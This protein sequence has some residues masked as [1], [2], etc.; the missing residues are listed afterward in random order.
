MTDTL[1]RVDLPRQPGSSRIARSVLRP[2]ACDLGEHAEDVALLVSE[3]LANAVEHGNGDALELSVRISDG[4]LRA[5]VVDG[6]HGFEPPE[7]DFDPLRPHGHGLELVDRIAEGWGVYEGNSTHV[8][9]EL[10][11]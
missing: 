3:L 11:V 4:R 9:F 2:L 10:D 1:L 6:G 7:F 5:E 8:W